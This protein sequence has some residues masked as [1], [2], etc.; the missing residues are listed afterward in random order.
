MAWRPA[1][2]TFGGGVMAFDKDQL[3]NWRTAVDSDKG[4]EIANLTQT[5]RA[6]G[7]APDAPELKRVPAPFDKD[8]PR[9][10]LLRHKSFKLWRQMP[11]Q[12]WATPITALQSGADDLAP[13]L[14]LLNRRL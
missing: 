4:T 9:A 12:D 2:S 7:Y 1:T 5:L 3:T 13:L 8:H 10:E 6:K 14:D 11:E